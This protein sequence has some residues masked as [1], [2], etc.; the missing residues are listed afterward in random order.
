MVLIE[1]PSVEARPMYTIHSLSSV[2]PGNARFPKAGEEEEGKFR[3][4]AHR[5]KSTT[6][7]SASRSRTACGSEGTGKCVMPNILE[8]KPSFFFVQRGTLALIRPRHQAKNRD[9]PDSDHTIYM[10]STIRK[11]HVTPRSLATYSNF[12]FQLREKKQILPPRV[13]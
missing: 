9:W 11:F 10:Y 5:S 3:G 6:G 13:G 4:Y 1:N 12:K 7:H 2:H 8:E